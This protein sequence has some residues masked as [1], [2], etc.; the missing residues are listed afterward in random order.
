[1]LSIV[2]A[3]SSLV[4]SE[5]LGSGRIAVLMKELLFVSILGLKRSFFQL[6]RLSWVLNYYWLW[7]VNSNVF[8]FNM[9]RGCSLQVIWVKQAILSMNSSCDIFLK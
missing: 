6:M 2:R 4:C 5:G 8:Y 1:M 9:M 3:S 7:Y